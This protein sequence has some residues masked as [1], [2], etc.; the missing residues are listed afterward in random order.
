[1]S[2]SDKR[3]LVYKKDSVRISQSYFTIR[4]YHQSVLLGEKPLETL[5]YG[6]NRKDGR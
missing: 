3:L 6:T 4:G 1:M 5:Q 2:S